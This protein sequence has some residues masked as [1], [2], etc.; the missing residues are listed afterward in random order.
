M[1]SKFSKVFPFVFVL[2][3]AAALSVLLGTAASATVC[4]PSAGC[5]GT[6][7]VPK[8]GQIFIGNS[9]GTYNVNYLTAGSNI[10]IATSSGGLTITGSNSGSVSTSSPITAFNFPYW[11]NVSG[12]LMGTSTLFF[13]STT[14]NV[15]IGT[16]SPAY[17]LDVVK[18][19]DISAINQLQTVARIKVSDSTGGTFWGGQSAGLLFTVTNPS[20]L[21]GG[22]VAA[23]HGIAE[24]STA[25]G[26]LAFHTSQTGT[27]AERMRIDSNGNVGIGTAQPSSTLHV[28]GNAIISGTTSSTGLTFTNATG[29]G[30]FTMNGGTVSSSKLTFTNATGSTISALAYDTQGNKYVT[31]TG[32]NIT[33]AGVVA[34]VFTIATSGVGLSYTTSSGAL[35]FSWT[36]PGYTTSTLPSSSGVVGSLGYTGATSSFTIPTGVTSMTVFAVGA[37]GYDGKE[38]TAGSGN[39]ASGTISV[40]AGTTYYYCIGGTG[41]SSTGAGGFCGGGAG[42]A[43]TAGG[44]G[45]STWVSTDSKFV[46]STVIIAAAGGGG[47]GGGI[48]TGNGGFGGAGGFPNGGGGQVGQGAGGNSQPGGGGTQT[49]GG[50]GGAPDGVR[51]PGVVGTSGAGGA[52]GVNS[53]GGGGGG[54]GYWGGGGGGGSEYLNSGAGGGGGGSSY[55]KTGFTS[56]STATSTVSTAGVNGSLTITYT[57]YPRVGTIQFPATSSTLPLTITF[58]NSFANTP[59]CLLTPS[60]NTTAYVTAV[61]ASSLTFNVGTFVPNMFVNYL[62]L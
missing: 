13:S 19:V 11:A 60:A 61:S 42:G 59:S 35:A 3:V 53:T 37:G 57:T 55:F 29:S 23:I 5:T 34:S 47:G 51:N 22:D 62:C 1:N 40:T 32:S 38:A 30:V 41:V 39:S 31:S 25:N 58:A 14:G 21:T 12:G 17:N 27:P 49:G 24:N 18:S 50:A 10:T 44:G 8:S 56:T 20:S 7:T 16:A 52:G 2:G 45:G 6:G 46:S 4:F 28:I 54:G 15:G 48:G 33:F 36:N 9:S 26:V 43:S